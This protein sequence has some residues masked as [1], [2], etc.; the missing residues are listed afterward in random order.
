MTYLYADL[1]GVEV[2]VAPL[3]GVVGAL[4]LGDRPRRADSHVVGVEVGVDDE[5]TV[6]HEARVVT[7]CD[8]DTR[9]A[10]L[11]IKT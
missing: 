4:E 3:V 8:T 11:R 5:S 6:E 2:G 10:L 9:H 7:R 1:L